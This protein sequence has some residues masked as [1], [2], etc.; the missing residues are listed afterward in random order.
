MNEISD[1]ASICALIHIEIIEFLKK[2]ESDQA[3]IKNQLNHIIHHAV[4]DIAHNNRAILNVANGA[5]IAC[6]GALDVALKDALLISQV[7]RDEIL[8]NNSLNSTLLNVRFG[9]NL[10]EAEVP[11]N[12]NEKPSIV[13]ESMV[14]AQR[15][16]HFAK[17]N[18]ILVSRPYYEMASKLSQEISQMFDYHDMQAHEQEIYAVRPHKLPAAIEE[19]QPIST[20]Q[21]QPEKKQLTVSKIK[22]S[23]VP[24]D[25]LILGLLILGAFF[26]LLKQVSTPIE[27]TIKP[28]ITFVQPAPQVSSTRPLARTRP[29]TTTPDK[30]VDNFLLPN[31]SVEKLPLI[32]KSNETK[33]MD[34]KPVENKPVET[35]LVEEGL[36]EKKPVEKEFQEELVQKTVQ[37]KADRKMAQKKARLRHVAKTKALAQTKTEIKTQTETPKNTAAKPVVS[38]DEKAAEKAKSAEKNKTVWDTFKHNVKQGGNQPCSQAKIAMNQC[39]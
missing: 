28:T 25:G 23:Y 31:E 38:K 9:I 29:I 30:S 1:K 15:I 34:D 10:G 17:L 27:P 11:G 39:R 6:I 16:M 8:E 33:L 35:T 13:G 7:I 14:E 4:V 26:V 21:L 36:A 12:M 37:K 32:A 20:S 5:I 3:A 18:Q 19:P 2:T 24:L 22:R